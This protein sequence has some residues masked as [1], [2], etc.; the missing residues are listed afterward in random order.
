MQN[1]IAQLGNVSE[2]P[3]VDQFA[4]GAAG[5]SGFISIIVKMVIVLA[6]MYGFFNLIFAGYA[7]MSA[8]GDSKRIQAATAKIWQTILGLAIAAASFVIAAL[9]GQLLFG[10]PKF[11]LQLRVFG[12]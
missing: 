1:L 3:G 10:D 11:L 7:F 9:I 12:P 2:P 4:S 6:S 8:G 5:L